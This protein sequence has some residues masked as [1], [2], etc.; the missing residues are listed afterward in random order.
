MCCMYVNECISCIVPL[1]VIS[2]HYLYSKLYETEQKT[3]V[4]KN[5]T[6]GESRA[7]SDNFFEAR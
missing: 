6:R 5:Y 1:V 4:T 3:N 2:Y 7:M